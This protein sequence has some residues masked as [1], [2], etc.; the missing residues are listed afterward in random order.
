VGE[1]YISN[2]IQHKR[3]EKVQASLGPNF[4]TL[5]LAVNVRKA[6]KKKKFVQFVAICGN[7]PFVET[8]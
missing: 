2:D 8:W 7:F 1:Y 3:S 5:K 6:E 4:T